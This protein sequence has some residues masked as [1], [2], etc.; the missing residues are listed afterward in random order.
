MDNSEETV[1][2]NQKT[3]KL[4]SELL[5]KPREMEVAF[6]LRMLRVQCSL[7]PFSFP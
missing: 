2:V 6:A 3:T 1:E 4:A 7:L 5:S